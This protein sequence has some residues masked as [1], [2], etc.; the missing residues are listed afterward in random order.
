MCYLG[1][2]YLLVSLYFLFCK[3]IN[4]K[5]L[6]PDGPEEQIVMSQLADWIEHTRKS[7]DKKNKKTVKML[8]PLY[9]Q[10]LDLGL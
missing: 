6:L 8:K 3:L 5:I 7:V 4:V 10:L 2:E 1:P 9:H